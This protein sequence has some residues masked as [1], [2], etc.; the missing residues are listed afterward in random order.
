M[1]RFT[2]AVSSTKG[3]ELNNIKCLISKVGLCGMYVGYGQHVLEGIV[4]Y[5]SQICIHQIMK[6]I[7]PIPINFSN[8]LIKF[9]VNLPST[10]AILPARPREDLDRDEF[11]DR[12]AVRNREN[13]LNE[14]NNN[15]P[16]ANEWSKKEA[17]FNFCKSSSKYYKELARLLVHRTPCL[18]VGS[19]AAYPFAVWKCRI[20]KKFIDGTAPSFDSLPLFSSLCNYVGGHIINYWLSTF[21]YHSLHRFSQP[22]L[23]EHFMV[24][25]SIDIV[26][27]FIFSKFWNWLNYSFATKLSIG[28]GIPINQPIHNELVQRPDDFI[29]NPENRITFLQ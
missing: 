1:Y 6:K 22:M 29:L 25:S 11:F 19:L 27:C 5:A 8:L 17:F 20:I 16:T 10:P 14:Q 7:P 26:C 12:P 18:I 28:M 9:N 4:N 24:H 15:E 3:K 2:T 13:R 21:L 23:N